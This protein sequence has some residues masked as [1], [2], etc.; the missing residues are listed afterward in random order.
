M[1][2]VESSSSSSAFV[3]S[4]NAG[5]EQMVS[6]IPLNQEHPVLH[7]FKGCWNQFLWQRLLSLQSQLLWCA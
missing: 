5:M 2:G 6:Q 1:E 4:S 7:E 3:C